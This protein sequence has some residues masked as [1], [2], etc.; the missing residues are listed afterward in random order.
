V[1]EK[2]KQKAG[3]RTISVCANP[4]GTT[5]Y[6]AGAEHDEW[7]LRQVS[8]VLSAL[9]GKPDDGANSAVV[10]GM[11]DMRAADPTEG[12]LIGQITAAN[13]AALRMYHL[14]WRQPPE[15]LD[16]R[17]K[18]LS[19][20]D[21]TMRTVMMLTERLDHHRGQ[22]Q[23]QIVVKHVTVN[24]DQAVVTDTVVAGKNH[25]EITAGKLLVARS[26]ALMEILE[27]AKEAV[28]VGGD[29]DPK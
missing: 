26:D 23:Q 8:N 9:P 25:E 12:I 20:A 4:R 1:T 6:I 19:Q 5:K 10:G 3:A 11:I 13:E 17:M 29:T 16:A 14:A 24:A 15:Y 22:G 7:T 28:P 18:Y 21:K 27:P 2:S